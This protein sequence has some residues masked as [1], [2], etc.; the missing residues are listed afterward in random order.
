MGFAEAGAGLVAA[1][2]GDPPP[3]EACSGSL[4]ILFPT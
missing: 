2:L 1:A 3:V 4:D